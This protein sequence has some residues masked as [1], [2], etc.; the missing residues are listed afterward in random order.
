MI[1]DGGILPDF[2]DA[3]VMPSSQPTM[4]PTGSGET[5][6]AVTDDFPCDFDDGMGTD[7]P[8]F[9]VCRLNAS[10]D[11]YVSDCLSIEDDEDTPIGTMITKNSKLDSCGCC[12]VNDEDGGVLPDFCDALPMMPTSQPT[13]MP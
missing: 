3:S 9:T 12:D 6:A 8:G 2:C 4:M 11:K 1:E 7:V 13:K 5:C 10:Q